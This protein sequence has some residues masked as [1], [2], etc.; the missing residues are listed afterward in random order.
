ML[1]ALEAGAD[2]VADDGDTWRDHVRSVADVRP[3]GGARGRRHRG[4]SRPTRR[5]SRRLVPVTDP[6]TPRSAAHH[7]AF[8]DNDDVQDVYSQLRH[9]RRHHGSGS[10]MSV[11]VGDRAPEFTLPGTGGR[12]VLAGGLRRP[13]AGPR[14]LSRRR[15]AGVHQ[16]T[17]LLQRRPRPVRRA[18][19]PGPSASPPRTSPATRSSRA[20][21]ASS[22]RC[23]PT[24]TRSSP[25]CTAR[26]DRS[27]SRG[28]ACS[29]STAVGH[30]LCP[31]GDRRP[32]LPPGHRTPRGPPRAR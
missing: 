30:P 14:L 5:W 4:R 31:P 9:Q 16:A 8:E 24:P 2:D 27:V 23:S 32:H 26:S 19:R 7:R 21:T 13:A 6:R 17:E 3:P 22:S 25:G 1:A 20:S 29:S 11:G 18:R 10:R 15:H 28:A 12:D